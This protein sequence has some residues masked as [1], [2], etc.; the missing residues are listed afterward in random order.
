MNSDAKKSDM[1]K[2]L[3]LLKKSEEFSFLRDKRVYTSRKEKEFS[4]FYHF[5]VYTKPVRTKQ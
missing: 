3:T 1:V 2:V 4:P 5:F